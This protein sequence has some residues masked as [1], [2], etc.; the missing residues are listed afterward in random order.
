MN[1]III[2]YLKWLNIMIYCCPQGKTGNTVSHT[3]MLV[4]TVTQL[5]IELDS[6]RIDTNLDNRKS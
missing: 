5:V 6:N 1:H 3:Q 4:N 2:Y